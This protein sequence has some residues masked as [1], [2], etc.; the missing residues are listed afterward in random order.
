MIFGS[1]ALAAISDMIAMEYCPQNGSALARSLAQA[2]GSLS[3]FRNTTHRFAEVS[4]NEPDRCKV[5]MDKFFEVI[6]DI[7]HD[8]VEAFVGFLEKYSIGKKA[9]GFR[10]ELLCRRTKI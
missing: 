4:C 1:L 2:K 3:K 7:P 8:L 10:T 6:A 9:T 5:A